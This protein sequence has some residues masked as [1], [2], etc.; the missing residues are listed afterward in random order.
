MAD[1]RGLNGRSL[2]RLGNN[3]GGSPPFYLH[4]SFDA[5]DTANPTVLANAPFA[6]RIL[7]ATVH[8]TETNS[9]G[10]IRVDN[11]STA[12]SDAITCATDTNVTRLGTV[13]DAQYEIA[14]GGS[15]KLTG[16]NSAKGEIYI[17]CVRT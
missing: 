8:C 12:I 11:G 13:D 6:F 3:L 4:Y 15:V 16:A 17:L 9:S 7:E 5:A 14:K 10:T 2:A 1:R